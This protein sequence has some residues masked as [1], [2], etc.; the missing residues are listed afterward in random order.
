[1]AIGAANADLVYYATFTRAAELLS[2]C[3]LAMAVSRWGRPDPAE[4]P[5]VVG[6]RSA[7]RSPSP[8]S[9]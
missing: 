4:R 3:L 5:G 2:G 7:A 9:S 6:G 8:A 1:M